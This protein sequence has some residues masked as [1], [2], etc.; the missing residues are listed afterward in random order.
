MYDLIIL[1]GG[2]AGV[3]AAVYASRK[4]LKTLLVA[5][6]FGGQSSVSSEIFN[7]IGTPSISGM[8]LAK[9]LEKHAREYEGDCLTIKHEYAKGI[10]K[11]EN[12]FSVTTDASSYVAKTVLV[13]T[14]SGRK[15]LEAKGADTFEHKGLTYC[16]TCDGP[17]FSGMD[18]AVLGGG[19][20]AFDSALQ[21]LSYCKSVTL[22][23]RSDTF[24]ADEITVE[25]ARAIPHMHIVTNAE[26]L[27]VTGEVFVNGIVYK[28]KITN[29][30][31]TLPVSGIFVEI[32][33]IPNTSFVSPLIALDLG[34][35][36]PV[37]G[38]TQRTTVPGV[39]AA[40]DCTNGLYHQNNIA[41]GDAV[42]A[43]EDIF[44]YIQKQ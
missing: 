37:D 17:L 2:P 7:W 3:A 12:L 32:G 42:K 6:E 35:K 28:D 38:M 19:N 11:D 26:V 10:S 31:T 16:A 24:R 21:L 15:K 1:G 36:I 44:L 25:K 33:Q 43:L 20:A 39:W 4:R 30:V 8:D 13:T 14:G 9:S 27:E 34:N 18:V 23:H 41:V 5:P 29:E 22:I 40:G